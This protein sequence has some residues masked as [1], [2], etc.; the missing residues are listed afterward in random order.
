MAVN[1]EISKTFSKQASVYEQAAKV[2][3]EI[4][5][6]LLER[7]HYLKINP[8]FILDLGCGTGFFSKEL[9]LLYPK[10]RIIGL[11][12]VTEMLVQARKKQSWRRKWP[13]VAADMN[14]LP[15]PT[16]LFDLIFA[17]QVIHWSDSLAQVFKELNRIMKVNACLMFT[18]LGPDTF[19]E[20]KISW[21]A[22]D[23]HAHINSFLDMH[24][25]GDSL[26]EAHFLDPVMDMEWLTLHYESVPHLIRALKNQG[27]KNI[28]PLRNKG[29]TG[30]KAWDLFETHYQEFRTETEKY[31]L[32][33]EVVYGHAW[34][35][36]PPQTTEGIETYIPL[37][38]IKTLK[39]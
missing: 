36:E 39:K 17:N 24:E 26:L 29:L 8:Q 18:T 1:N 20:L 10:A 30:R 27:V 15:F 7:L 33:Y 13:L 14:Q 34:K 2:Q 6:R 28:N 4:G 5:T 3:K 31:P 22:A 21:T 25:V 23:Q 12:M 16:G 35:G 37:S 32:T 38:S 9:A 19:K 11:D